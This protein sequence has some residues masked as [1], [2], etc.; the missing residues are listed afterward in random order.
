MIQKIENDSYFEHRW[1]DDVKRIQKVLLD[2]DYTST[3]KDCA[4]LWDNYSEDMCAGWMCL[5]EDDE[6]LFSILEYRIP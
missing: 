1:I 6:E 5:P 3:L 4:N 2:N